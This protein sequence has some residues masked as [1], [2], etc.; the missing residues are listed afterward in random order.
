MLA[1]LFRIDELTL[2][3]VVT[4]RTDLLEGLMWTL[5]TDH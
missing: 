2:L 3:L 5:S 1:Q 4:L